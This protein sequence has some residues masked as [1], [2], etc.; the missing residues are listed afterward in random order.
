MLSYADG[1]RN[2]H[3]DR[4]LGIRLRYSESPELGDYARGYRR[5]VL[6][7]PLKEWWQW[8]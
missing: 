3:A 1:F 2:G 8:K 4:L 5:G 7:L 6:G